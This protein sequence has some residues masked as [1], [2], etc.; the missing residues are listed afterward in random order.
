MTF[1]G[2]EDDGV[3]LAVDDVELGERHRV[4]AAAPRLG[5][6]RQSRD[7]V[8]VGALRGQ[9]ARDRLHRDADGQQQAF[10]LRIGRR[11]PQAGARH[12]CVRHDAA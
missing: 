4:A 5:R 3:E 11:D 12:P 2:G 1:R 7:M 9:L 10:L 8:G 6:R